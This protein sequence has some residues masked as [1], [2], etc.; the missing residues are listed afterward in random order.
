MK[1]RFLP[2]EVNGSPVAIVRDLWPTMVLGATTVIL[3]AL[4]ISCG[5]ITRTV[6]AP[7][8]VPGATFMGSQSCAECHAENKGNVAGGSH[9]RL[10]AAGAH[11]ANV[12]CE[13]C[14]GPASIHNQ[15]GG[16]PRTI[17]NPK[18]SPDACFQCHLDT[19]SRVKD[20][21]DAEY[22]DFAC[23]ECHTGG[24]LKE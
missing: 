21:T 23:P 15:S 13:S 20:M 18:K 14:H 11:A 22:S 10:Q 7:P 1:L 5:T 16:A 9:A 12:G 8:A 2:K 17:I 6:M 19:H 4:A 24:L 3:A